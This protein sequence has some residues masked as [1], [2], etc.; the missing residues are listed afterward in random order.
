[1][2]L[3]AVAAVMVDMKKTLRKVLSII[4]VVLIVALSLVIFIFRDKIGNVSNV[5]YLGLMLLCFLA[6]ATVFLPSPSLMIAA[7]CALVMNPW[8]VAL[9]AAVGSA[10][11]EFVGYALG[12]AA[13]DLS[14]RF[15]K[16]LDKITSK[17]HN[18]ILLVFILAALPLPLFDVAGVYSGGT[19]LNPLW[20]FLACF[21]GK[22][23][24]LLVY[25]RAYDIL[26]WLVSLSPPLAEFLSGLL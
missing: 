3:Y 19:K 2:P 9:C 6:N 24:K 15:K 23:I 17:V 21:L 4:V 26:A 10:A 22:F 8:L 13:E 18:P 5:S 11:G 12:F 16:L 14:P 20:F 7:S 25:T 1:M